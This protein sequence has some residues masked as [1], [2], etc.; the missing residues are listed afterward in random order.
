MSGWHGRSRTSEVVRGGRR[1]SAS[2][3][4]WPRWRIAEVVK[5]RGGTCAAARL[6]GGPAHR[7]ASRL[8]DGTDS[9]RRRSRCRG[10]ELPRDGGQAREAR[11]SSSSAACP[12]ARRCPSSRLSTARAGSTSTSGIIR[13]VVDPVLEKGRAAQLAHRRARPR[14]PRPLHGVHARVP[15]T[16][17]PRPVRPAAPGRR[18]DRRTQASTS[19]R[20]TSRSGAARPTCPGRTCGAG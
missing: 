14:R 12:P 19:S 11:C 6:G 10:E 5:P 3:P 20:P 16:P 13:R 4:A 1:C 18:A 17:R 9:A 15:R 8:G 2:W 7:R